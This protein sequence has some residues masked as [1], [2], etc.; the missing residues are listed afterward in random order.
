MATEAILRIV[1]TLQAVALAG[2][3]YKLAKKKKKKV[4]DFISYGTTAIVG[5][6]LIKEQAA[7]LK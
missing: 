3:S 4:G 5:S 1:P 6:A 7:F 2:H